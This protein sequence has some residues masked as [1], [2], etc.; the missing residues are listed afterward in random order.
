MQPIEYIPIMRAYYE[1]SGWGHY[2]VVTPRSNPWAPLG[3]PLAEC[4]VALVCSAGLSVYGQPPFNP[5]GADDLSIR[6]IPVGTPPDS[7]IISYN[8]FDHTDADADINCVFP[9]ARLRELASE[10]FVGGVAPIAYG[11]G[12]G[13]WREPSTPERLQQQVAPAIAS[14]CRSQGADAVLLIPT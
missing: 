1:R 7:L 6:E 8:Y 4:R 9:A 2:T 10:G 3:K 13:R 12:V 11:M 5:E 14:G